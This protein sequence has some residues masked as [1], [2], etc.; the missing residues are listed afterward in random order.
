MRKWSGAG[1]AETRVEEAKCPMPCFRLASAA[2]FLH[3]HRAA[4]GLFR[5]GLPDFL[6]PDFRLLIQ[7]VAQA[8]AASRRGLV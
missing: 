3:A 5:L 8:V 6:H 4:Q 2:R 1:T 7:A